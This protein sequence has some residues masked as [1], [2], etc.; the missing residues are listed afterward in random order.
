MFDRIQTLF[1]RLVGV[2]GSISVPMA[3]LRPHRRLPSRAEMPAC[4]RR[5]KRVISRFS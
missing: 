5:Q 1:E 3:A 2:P 4:W